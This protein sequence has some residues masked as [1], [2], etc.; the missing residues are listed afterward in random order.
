MKRFCLS[1][2]AC[3]IGLS[4]NACDSTENTSNGSAAAVADSESKSNRCW[5]KYSFSKQ[6]EKG[7]LYQLASV[8][9]FGTASR[10]IVESIFAAGDYEMSLTPTSD[11]GCL[12]GFVIS[13]EYEG[14]N[15]LFED[16]CPI[17]PTGFKFPDGTEEIRVN[18]EK[19]F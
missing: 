9:K 6:S 10:G 1:V 3:A 19:Y 17:D 15:Y 12:A 14:R 13:T 18:C 2:V 11:G 8:G 4:V 5:K 16:S 7:L